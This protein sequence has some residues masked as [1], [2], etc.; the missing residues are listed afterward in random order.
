MKCKRGDGRG[1]FEV[2][3]TSVAECPA[4]EGNKQTPVTTITPVTSE[5]SCTPLIRTLF[6]VKRCAGA[7]LLKRSRSGCTLPVRGRL[8]GRCRWIFE[9]TPPPQTAVPAPG[10]QDHPRGWQ[11]FLLPQRELEQYRTDQLG[12]EQEFTFTDGI[13]PLLRPFFTQAQ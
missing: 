1:P 2:V 5:S 9:S 8:W 12:N 3:A 10:V 13:L 4:P 7:L 11:A 6:A